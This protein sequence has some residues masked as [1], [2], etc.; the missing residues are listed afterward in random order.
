VSAAELRHPNVLSFVTSCCAKPPPARFC[1]DFRRWHE[2]RCAKAV[3]AKIT[4][5]VL[6]LLLAL[7]AAAARADPGDGVERYDANRDGYIS[8]DE[9]RNMG[10]EPSAFRASDADSDGRLRGEELERAE[11]RD[12]RLKA[13][14]AW[15]SAKVTAA[16]LMDRALT[17]ADMRVTTRKGRV[18]L[19]G[20]VHSEDDAKAAERIAWRVEGV[21]AV[22]NSLSV[23]PRLSAQ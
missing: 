2:L 7:A 23:R 16:L 17:I 4:L 3:L 1:A 22:I 15:V 10:G 9:W 13:G 12:A 11:A 6:A 18:R 20:V 19:A 5:A 14:D 8:F 21:H